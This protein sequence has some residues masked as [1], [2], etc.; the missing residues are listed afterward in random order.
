MPHVIRLRGPWRCE[1]LARTRRRADG[2]SEIVS[3][4]LPPAGQIQVPSDW[5]EVLGENFRGRV[6]YSRRFNRPSGMSAVR[7]VDLVIECVDAFGAVALNDDVL[8]TIPPGLHVFRSDLTARLKP[9]NRLTI[10][11]EL[12]E[13]LDFSAALARR[14]RDG[15]PGGLIG[16]VR[17]E[18]FAA[19]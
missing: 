13:C 3:G 10:D 7:R 18:I 2:T 19:E 12:P 8:G 6:R 11:V 5:G 15:R 17:L 1:A 9:H 16:E 14:G 4:E